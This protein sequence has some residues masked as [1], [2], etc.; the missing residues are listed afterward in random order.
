M[1]AVERGGEKLVGSAYGDT[2][3]LYD[4][5]ADPAERRNLAGRRPGRAAALA[6]ALDDAVAFWVA[7]GPLALSEETREQM[8]ALG[9]LD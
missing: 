8:R 7:P 6:A 2:V 3:E 9:Y 4:L 5:A 1:R